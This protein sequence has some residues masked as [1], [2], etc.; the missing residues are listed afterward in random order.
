MNLFFLYGPPAVGKLTIAKELG[1][2]TGL[3]V[4][5]NHSVVNPIAAVFGWDHPERKRLADFFRIEL[6]K[7]AAKE[8]KSLITTF[9][10]GGEA[11]DHFIHDSIRVVEEA[12]G[13]VI[14]VRLTAPLET[15]FERVDSVSRRQKSTMTAR[16]T[17]QKKLDEQPD[18]LAKALVGEHLEI[19]TSLHSPEEAA[20]IIINSLK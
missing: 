5:D 13:K 12:G 18:V 1:K 2:L 9:G 11:Y 14:F 8:D 6:F 15:L 19:D 10:G 16:E 7:A 20:Q 4:V 3:P 17:L